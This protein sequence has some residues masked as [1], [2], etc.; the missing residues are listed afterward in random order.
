LNA[1]PQ[2]RFELHWHLGELASCG[3]RLPFVDLEQGTL[4][5]ALPRLEAAIAWL[6]RARIEHYPEGKAKIYYSGY[7]FTLICGDGAVFADLSHLPVECIVPVGCPACG[8]A[9]PADRVGSP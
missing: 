5:R 9:T 8:R 6:G 4:E 3:S 1:D 7:G 2:Q